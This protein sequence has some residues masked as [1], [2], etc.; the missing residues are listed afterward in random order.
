[1]SAINLTAIKVANSDVAVLTFDL[2]N[3]K[4]NKLSTPVMTELKAHIEKLK[5]SNYK[6]VVFKSAKPK[7][8]IAGAD[9]EEI[10]ELG[11]ESTAQLPVSR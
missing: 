11:T 10:K 7:I 4:V 2:P 5:T 3:E 9:I 1:M 8:F 6:M